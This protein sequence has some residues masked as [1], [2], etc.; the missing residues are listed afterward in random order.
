LVRRASRQRCRW[1]STSNNA[2]G[3][4][5]DVLHILKQLKAAELKSIELVVVPV[6]R[7]LIKMVSGLQMDLVILRS[8]IFARSDLE[9]QRMELVYITNPPSDFKTPKNAKKHMFGPEYLLAKEKR[10]QKS[11]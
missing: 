11:P 2:S 5:Y 4:G 6:R 1:P 9:S 8:L 3:G 10:T 7:R